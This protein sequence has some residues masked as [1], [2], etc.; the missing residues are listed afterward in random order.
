MTERG[1]RAYRLLNDPDLQQAFA[2][3]KDAILDRFGKTPPSNTE[4]LIEC[5]RLLQLLDSVEANLKRAISDGKLEDFRVQQ[6]ERPPFLGDLI[7]WPKR[8]Q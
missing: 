3:V 5:R 6:D 1:D 4:Q 7:K 2:D 8:M